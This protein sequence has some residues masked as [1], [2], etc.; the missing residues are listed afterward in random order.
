[1]MIVC[2][3][4]DLLSVYSTELKRCKLVFTTH[5]KAKEFGTAEEGDHWLQNLWGVL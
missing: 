2:R 1:M 3:V 4:H 5:I